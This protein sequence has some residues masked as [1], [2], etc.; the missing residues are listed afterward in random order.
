MKRNKR[1]ICLCLTATLSGIMLI[2]EFFLSG[3]IFKESSQIKSSV[4]MTV[5][6]LLA[7]A[8]FI[9]LLIYLDYNVLKLRRVGA[10]LLFSLPALAVALNNLPIYPLASGLAKVT[11]PRWVV[12][13]LFLECLA[14][15][16]FEEICFRGVIFLGFLEKRRGSKK[17][18]FAAIILSSAVFGAIHLVNVF[19]GASIGATVL[20]IGYSFLI[21]AMC[22]VILMRTSNIWLCAIIHAVFNFCGAIVPRCGEGTIWEPFTVTLTV[23]V[24]LAVTVY[25][26]VA[27][28][29]IK[30]CE[31][32]VIYSK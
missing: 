26:T 3:L 13:L 14:V 16:L 17:G 8:V 15:G 20:Q 28:F 6:R 2:Y 4:D 30:K 24:A 10:S 9:I 22:S 11:S 23:L 1:S 32:D 5:T 21:G 29:K 19:F 25:M 12:A 18:Q 27:F 7:A 31:C